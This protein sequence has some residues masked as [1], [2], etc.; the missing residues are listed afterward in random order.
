MHVSSHHQPLL[1]ALSVAV[2][3]FTAYVALDLAGRQRA[4]AGAARWAWLGAAAVAMGGGIWSMHFIAMLALVTPVPVAYDLTITLVS[5]ALPIVVTGGALALTARDG[6]AWGRLALGGLVMGGGIVLMHYVGMAAITMDGVVTY[7]PGLVALS[8]LIAVAAATAALR[9]A[10]AIRTRAQRAIGA[11]TMGAAVIGMHFVGM[12]AAT[13]TFHEGKAQ[14]WFEAS[15]VEAPVLA[16]QVA[17]VTGIVL[18]LALTSSALAR[19]SAERKAREVEATLAEERQSSETLLRQSEERLR[20]AVQATGLG[21]WDWDMAR[22]AILW[23]ERTYAL[24]GL[25]P[26]SAVDYTRFLQAVHP[27]DRAVVEAAVRTALA[28]EGD[29]R[30]EAEFRAL[31]PDGAVRWLSTQG[32]T[33]FESGASAT[34]ERRPVRL[35]GTILDITARRLAEERLRASLQEKEMLLREVHHRVKNNM[36]AITAIL[37]LEA[38]QVADEKAREGFAAVGQRIQAMARLHEQLYSAQDLRRIDLGSYFAELG[39]G[40]AALH[41]GQPVCIEAAVEPL[42]CDLDTAMPLGLIANELVTN[43]LKHAFPDG[44][45]GTVRIRLFREGDDVVFE[46]SDDGVGSETGERAKGLGKRLIEA[47]AQ[48]VQ[49]QLDINRAGGYRSL[50]RMPGTRFTAPDA[51]VAPT[52]TVG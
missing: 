41:V 43:S 36:Q 6:L 9:L 4:T 37:Q 19:R 13:F 23:S 28:P 2:A 32:Q 20:L 11:V 17:G 31:Q 22:D 40:L 51:A 42:V 34:G 24:F 44:R 8:A 16:L 15:P 29:G 33:H 48:Q 27:D 39:Q 1:V 26:G 30:L 5:L 35:L 50:F 21:T 18:A 14:R 3:V 52:E 10:G 45:S 7:D 38:A 47:L 46:V 25:A 12:A 49:A